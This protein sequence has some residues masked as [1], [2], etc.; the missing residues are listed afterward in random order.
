[1]RNRLFSLLLLFP[2]L[3]L[4][5]CEQAPAPTESLTVDATP[6]PV[7]PEVFTEID[8]LVYVNGTPITSEELEYA[9]VRIFGAAGGLALLSGAEDKLL[10]SL[11]AS[12]AI[13]LNAEQQL[14]DDERSELDR[15]VAAYR[16]ELLV[17][18][19]LTT[20]VVAQPVTGEMVQEYYQQNPEE[21]G[22]GEE[23]TFE[24]V[25]T[26][27]D[28][29]AE[30]RNDYLR[31]FVDLQSINDWKTWVKDQQSPSLTHREAKARSAILDQPLRQLVEKTQAGE[32]SAVHN[33]DQLMLV[34][35]KRVDRLAPKAIGQVRGEI[36]RKLAPVQLRQAVKAVSAQAV[37]DAKVEY[38]SN[39]VGAVE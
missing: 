1:M 24:Y 27:G 37:K 28:L 7:A 36:R 25:A 8:A 35:V 32:V 16:E 30:Q 22:G 20:H 14:A 18:H 19:Y 39:S 23:R 38:A 15:K 6:D 33:G 21:F 34:R 4:G 17:K 5:A 13:A 26:V 2:L 31:R 29:S 10:D 3:M 9:K 12:R 11:I